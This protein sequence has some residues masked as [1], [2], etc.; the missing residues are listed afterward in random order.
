MTSQEGAVLGVQW[1]AVIHQFENSRILAGASLLSQRVFLEGRFDD[2]RQNEIDFA[3][4]SFTPSLSYEHF[5][6]DHFS[7][8]GSLTLPFSS[9]VMSLENSRQQ[10]FAVTTY[11]EPL[12][13][14]KYYF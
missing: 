1:D 10:I 11:F 8:G 5:L 4:V 2:S 7:L 9:V 14:A 12:M 3:I 13:F 6:G